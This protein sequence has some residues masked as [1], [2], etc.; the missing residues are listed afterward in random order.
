MQTVPPFDFTEENTKKREN[1]NTYIRT[2]LK[3][4][5]DFI[6]EVAPYLGK[7][8]DEPQ[9]TKFGGHPNEEGSAIWAEAFCECAVGYIADFGR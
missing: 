5:A 2:V 6:F 4:K 1:V 9:N 3:D 8:A 7:S